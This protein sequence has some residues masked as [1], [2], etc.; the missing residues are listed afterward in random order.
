[1]AGQGSKFQFILNIRGVDTEVLANAPEGW[2]N[3]AI[4]YTRSKIYGGLFRGETLPAKYV[5]KAAMLLRTECYNNGVA[6]F[7]KNTINLQNPYTWGYNPIYQGR[8]DFSTASDDLT[9]FSVNSISD[10]FSTQLT[11]NDSIDYAIPMDVDEA[12]NLELTPLNLPEAADII[13]LGNSDH[14]SNAFFQLQIVN[15]QQNS[16]N[17]SVYDYSS[18][19]LVV[20]TPVYS[21]DQHYFFFARASCNVVF[22]I[23]ITGIV[24]FNGGTGTQTYSI[25]VVNETGTIVNTIYSRTGSTADFNISLTFSLPVVSGDRL[26]LYFATTDG[27]SNWG[28]RI[29]SGT[30]NLKYQTSSPATMCKAL[31]ANYVFQQL[32]QAMNTNTDSAPNQP[33]PSKSLLL[34]GLLSNLLITCSDSIRLATGSLFHTGDTLFPGSYKVVSGSVIYGGTP[35]TLNQIFPYQPSV[36]TFTGTGVV[37]KILSGFVGAVYNTGD[38]LQAGGTYLAGGDIGTFITYNAISYSPGQTFVYFLGVETFSGS[39]DSSFVEQVGVKVE[40]IINFKSYWQSIYSVMGGNAAFGIESVPN[41]DPTTVVA[42]PTINQCFIETLDYVYRGSIGNLDVGVVDSS[43]KLVPAVDL[44]PN[45]IIVGYNDPQLST[46]NG[47]AEVN[48]TQTYSTAILNPKNVLNLVSEINAAPYVIE[49]IRISQN[50]TA[51]SRSSNDNHFVWKNT[52]PENTVPFVYYHP[53]RT[54]GIMTNPTTGKKMIS[55]VDPSYYN[56]I[57]SPKQNLLRGGNYLASVFYNMQGYKLTL[58]AAPKNTALVTVDINGRR[59]SEADP[60]NISDLRDSSGKSLA[61]FIPIYASFKP[62]LPVNALGMID[63]IPYGFMKFTYNGIQYKAFADTV[64]VDVGEN[65]EQELKVLL[66]PD[67]DITTL[68]H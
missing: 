46:L 35:F 23:A 14:R 40:M 28:F 42:Q 15:N 63:N 50:D 27:D 66:T 31:P 39:D 56:W 37:E 20:P 2:L 54:E 36:L 25:N 32:L 17:P 41:T 48:S 57:L 53:L 30:I 61:L 3:T 22:T 13:L 38:T 21:T 12:V 4:K 47:Y 44:I 1:M 10:D 51:A 55:G 11:A 19:F 5:T 49:E 60:V 16:V 24:F 64:S 18:Q 43:I 34:T 6:A 62:G 45:S 52:A 58:S 29:N 59:V 68:I 65:S 33:V 26:F 7:V 67:N 9:S 8:L